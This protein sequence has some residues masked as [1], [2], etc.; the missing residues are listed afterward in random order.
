[1]T[2]LTR[3]ELHDANFRDYENLHTNMEREGFKRTVKGSNGSTYHLPP[4]EYYIETSKT[5]EV[6]RDA[7]RRAASA[8]KVS[9]AVL[10]AETNQLA[11]IGLP[12]VQYA[13]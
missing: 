12:T 8:V 10:V 7:A 3:V 11:W 1:M 6:V 13:S 2:Y 4:A 5:I 9:N